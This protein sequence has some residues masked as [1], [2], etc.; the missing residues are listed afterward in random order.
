MNIKMYAMRWNS[1]NIDF[2]FAF[3]EKE[4]LCYLEDIDDHPH[5]KGDLYEI[6]STLLDG[7][8]LR[9]KTVIE[10]RSGKIVNPS[11]SPDDIKNAEKSSELFKVLSLSFYGEK[12]FSLQMS[13]VDEIL[14]K[15]CKKVEL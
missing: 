8:L 7:M 5:E 3:N 10:D 15:Y 6:D 1:G 13:K 14:Q 2:V 9:P 12:Y 11:P 4:A